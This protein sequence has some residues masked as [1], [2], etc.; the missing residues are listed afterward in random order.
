MGGAGRNSGREASH[1]SWHF[2]AQPAQVPGTQRCIRRIKRQRTDPVMK[3]YL[4]RR[5]VVVPLHQGRACAPPRGR[6]THCSAHTRKELSSG[7]F[8]SVSSSS[9]DPSSSGSVFGFFFFCDPWTT[10]TVGGVRARRPPAEWGRP[11]PTPARPAFQCR[12]THLLFLVLVRK[13]RVARQ[14]FGQR[15]LQLHTVGSARGKA[16]RDAAGSGRPAPRPARGRGHAG[17]EHEQDSMHSTRM[18]PLPTLAA[19]WAVH[20]FK[21]RED[22]RPP[23]GL[24]RDPLLQAKHTGGKVSKKSTQPHIADHA[25]SARHARSGGSATFPGPPP[26]SLQVFQTCG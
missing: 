24:W 15:R 19:C 11:L 26:R 3:P 5:A 18:R 20:L 9:S 8:G 10:H 2:P 6:A 13:L 4:Q 23:A 21:L 12:P 14:R 16:L 1:P 7:F 22:V 25:C 17:Y